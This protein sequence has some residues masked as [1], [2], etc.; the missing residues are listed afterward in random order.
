MDASCDEGG[1][2][3]FMNFKLFLVLFFSVALAGLMTLLA[4]QLQSVVFGVGAVAVSAGIGFYLCRKITS[5]AMAVFSDEISKLHELLEET[6]NSLEN[7]QAVIKQNTADDELLKKG[8]S[9]LVDGDFSQEGVE[10]PEIVISLRQSIISI[11]EMSQELAQSARSGNFEKSD[12]SG[13]LGDWVKVPSEINTILETAASRIS[14]ADEL[15]HKHQKSLT[16]VSADFSSFVIDIKDKI[17]ELKENSGLVIERTKEVSASSN[18]LTDVS[19]QQKLTMGN[20]IAFSTDLINL[21]NQNCAS[22]K[23]AYTL[24]DE[25]KKQAVSA[26]YYI[27]TVQTAIDSTNE[28]SNSILQIL[29]AINDIA[30]QT[31]LIVLD[32]EASG[33][34]PTERSRELIAIAQ[35]IQDKAA[36]INNLALD[37]ISSIETS[38]KAAQDTATVFEHITSGSN[39]LNE[40]INI[41]EKQSIKQKN[42]VDEVDNAIKLMSNQQGKCSIISD[43]MAPASDNLVDLAEYLH[44]LIDKMTPVS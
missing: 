29:R 11:C 17:S 30:Y 16:K 6:K 39:K 31:N 33:Y 20:L 1:I 22:M 32:G 24:S 36:E 35:N 5:G 10:Y 26:G 3:Y 42:N 37:T 23:E 27:K 2:E 25:C 9:R 38:R 15:A 41:I 40:M 8:L 4:G 28:T 7:A 21:A 18:E 44:S 13:Y 43:E 19:A 34:A 14:A 12:V